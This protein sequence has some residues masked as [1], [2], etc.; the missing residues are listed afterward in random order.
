MNCVSDALTSLRAWRSDQ[1][2]YGQSLS[3]ERCIHRIFKQSILSALLY[4]N[5]LNNRVSHL[6]N[7]TGNYQKSRAG[8]Q[9]V[10]ETKI[11]RD[12][13]WSHRDGRRWEESECCRSR[14]N[15]STAEAV[16][17]PEALRRR[18]NALAVREAPTVALLCR[19]PLCHFSQCGCIL[20][21]HNEFL[22]S[23]TIKS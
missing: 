6:R 12:R 3:L 8:F 21:F 13:R 22:N 1:F 19:T 18:E 17:R 2:I 5:P 9:P 11:I 20:R 7:T 16:R 4:L 23:S 15:R 10:K 14:A